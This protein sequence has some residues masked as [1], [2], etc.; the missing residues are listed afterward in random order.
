M[1]PSR[2]A[3]SRPDLQAHDDAMR[4]PYRNMARELTQIL[5]AKLVAYIARVSE[6]RA[7]HEWAAE[8]REP[9][10]PAVG[11]RLR[12]GDRGTRHVCQADPVGAGQRVECQIYLGC[13]RLSDT[14][15]R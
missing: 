11:P 4:A 1:A 10:D 9:K 2:A 13:A 3:G 8:G 14:E 7:V 12:N 6:T 5:G 15:E